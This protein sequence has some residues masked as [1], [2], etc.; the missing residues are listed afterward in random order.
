MPNIAAVIKEE[1]A[2]ISRKEAKA[3]VAPLR[4]PSVRY[5]GE[6]ADLKSRVAVLEKANK[7]LLARLAKVEGSQPAPEATQDGGRVR[8][9]AKGMKSSRKKLGLSAA[10]FGK[11]LGI[12][13]QGVYNN[14]HSRG[15]LRLRAATKTAYLAV[16]GMG[17]KEAKQRLAE[18]GK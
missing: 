15:A 9:T 11:L 16:R 6:I 2:R 17:A 14:E 5:R 10:A 3:A 4:K 18:M 1:I 12:T 13:A 8:I 7:D